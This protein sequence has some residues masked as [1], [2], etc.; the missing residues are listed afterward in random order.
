MIDICECCHEPL[1]PDRDGCDPGLCWDCTEAHDFEAED[2]EDPLPTEPAD[3]DLVTSDYLKFY[4][5][6][7]RNKGPVVECRDGERWAHAVEAYMNGDNFWP[8]VWYIG[9]RGDVTLID[10]YEELH[11][12]E[13]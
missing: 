12:E 6:G 13:Q 11:N 5:H 8:N 4:V 10:M 1:E 9:E 2:D 7:F 3:D